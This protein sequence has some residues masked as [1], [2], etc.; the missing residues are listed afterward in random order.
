M[1]QEGRGSGHGGFR[2]A[3]T[4]HLEQWPA[5]R[6]ARGVV[7]T[8]APSWPGCSRCDADLARHFD[9]LALFHQL[10]LDPYHARAAQ[11]AEERGEEDVAALLRAGAAEMTRDRV[12]LV[13][14]DFSPKNLLVHPG[15]VMALDFEVVHWGNPDFDT[16]FLLTH[17]TLKAAH[18]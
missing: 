17:L 8:P 3:R 1:G 2:L 16:A 13:H 18:R 10:R 9:D 11:V 15:G 14:G 5:G 7:R 4:E 12:T 6:A